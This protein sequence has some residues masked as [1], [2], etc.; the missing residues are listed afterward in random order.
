VASQ[1][2]AAWLGLLA[3]AAVSLPMWWPRVRSRWWWL[4]AAVVLVALT[5][6]IVSRT[7]DVFQGDLRARADE[8]RMGVGVISDHPL[9]GVGP[10]GY[11]LAFPSVVDADYERRYTRRTTPDRAHNGALDTAA[12]FGLPG[13][14]AYLT[15]TVFLVGRSWRAVQTR[16]PLLMGAGA[17]V[18]GY[19]VQQQFLFPIAEIDVIFWL[20]AGIVV[21]TT[22]PMSEVTKPPIV[23]AIFLGSLSFLAL[24]GGV[25]D[26]AADHRVADAQQNPLI[27]PAATDQ[28]SSLRPDSIRYWLIAA[29]ARARNGD[30]P[31]AIGRIERA[32]SISHLDPILL[33]TKGRLLLAIA[34]STGSDEDISRVV[35]FYERLLETDP[36]NAQNLLRAG[37]AY[38]LAGSSAAAEEAFLRASDLAPTSAVPLANL[39]RLYLDTG[40]LENALEAYE[41][42][43][44]IDPTSPGLDEIAGLLRAGGAN[45]GG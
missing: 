41:S 18:T 2:R 29:D 36:H 34:G 44:A 17:A 40:R 31:A 24:L 15:G 28:A 20:L 45:I 16:K 13:L 3:A 21:A 38:S 9:L 12:I 22:G 32:L 11:R 37:A 4:G 5:T 35:G 8:W 23:M 27:A 42:A 25:A 39:A 30:W 19:L 14:V 26:V 7:A 1:T 33:A 43:V 10:E 6:P